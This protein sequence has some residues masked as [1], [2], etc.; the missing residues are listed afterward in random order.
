MKFCLVLETFLV[1]FITFGRTKYMFQNR[2]LGTFSPRDCL[3][4]SHTACKKKLGTWIPIRLYCWILS[5]FH[6]ADPFFK[7]KLY[8]IY[9]LEKEDILWHIFVCKLQHKHIKTKTIPTL[10]ISS[11]GLHMF[12]LDRVEDGEPCFNWQEQ[13]AKREWQNCRKAYQGN[14]GMRLTTA[15]VVDKSR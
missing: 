4:F 11:F 7:I 10:V 14:I 8:F 12:P 3:F 1:V 5:G 9:L 6:K 13:G 15:D 2:C